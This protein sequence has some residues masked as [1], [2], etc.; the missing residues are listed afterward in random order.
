MVSI[1]S[2]GPWLLMYEVHLGLFALYTATSC[3]ASLFVLYFTSA[4]YL[5]PA[6]FLKCFS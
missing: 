6:A 1:E 5:F 3:V 4:A 2:S